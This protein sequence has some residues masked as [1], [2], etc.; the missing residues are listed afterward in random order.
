MSRSPHLF[1]CH[2]FQGANEMIGTTQVFFMNAYSKI[3]LI[4]LDLLIEKIIKNFFGLNK[5][6]HYTIIY[7]YLNNFP[8]LRVIYKG[9]PSKETQNTKW[10]TITQNHVQRNLHKDK[11][12][13]KQKNKLCVLKFQITITKSDLK[14][15]NLKLYPKH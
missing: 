3:F 5:M 4:Y 1:G 2:A 7:I 15:N 11:K 13:A 14:T 6:L 10:E 12:I 8:K 9:S